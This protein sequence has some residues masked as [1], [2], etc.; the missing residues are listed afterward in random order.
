MAIV[1]GAFMPL[2]MWLLYILGSGVSGWRSSLSVDSGTLGL[3]IDSFVF[4]FSILIGFRE[5]FSRSYAAWN[6]RIFW[7]DAG[8]EAA[9]PD[10]CVYS[11]RWLNTTSPCPI[12]EAFIYL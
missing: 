3:S 8:V 1:L 4:I 10:W 7:L 11:G 9:P 5:A 2:K 6:E 12:D